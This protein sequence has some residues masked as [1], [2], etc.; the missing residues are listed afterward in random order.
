M[1]IQSAVV[2]VQSAYDAL[3]RLPD[4]SAEHAA[5]AVEVRLMME[6]KQVLT[7]GWN[8]A[9]QT[10]HSELQELRGHL[11]AWVQQQALSRRSGSLSSGGVGIGGGG[12]GGGGGGKGPMLG[13]GGGGGP[14]GRAHSA[15]VGCA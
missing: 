10:L 5:K 12:R 1:V 3:E 15:A 4:S 11:K 13:G 14:G 7:A 9:F 6:S 2:S 8:S